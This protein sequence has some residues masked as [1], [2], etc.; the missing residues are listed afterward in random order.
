M[1]GADHF[2]MSDDYSRTDVPRVGHFRTNRWSTFYLSRFCP[3]AL[4]NSNSLFRCQHTGSCFFISKLF[5]FFNKLFD[6]WRF[7][8]A[9]NDA[10][11]N[12]RKYH[13]FIFFLSESSS[14]CIWP[15]EHTFV[16]HAFESRS[17]TRVDEKNLS[18]PLTDFVT[19]VASSQNIYQRFR[20]AFKTSDYFWFF[21]VEI[22]FLHFVQNPIPSRV[23]LTQLL[24]LCMIAIH[25]EIGDMTIM[26][27]SSGRGI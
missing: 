14:P 26:H 17:R 7:L 22:Y 9:G 1:Q 5:Y 16:L 27:S 4:R 13:D 10:I 21:V 24:Y 15:V 12:Q 11:F 18:H 20:Q 19:R 6:R 3:H 25:V 2:S 8:P 23:C